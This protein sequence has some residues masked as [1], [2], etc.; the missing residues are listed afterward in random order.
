[1][2]RVLIS[3]LCA[4]ILF[5]FVSSVSAQNMAGQNKPY[6]NLAYWYGTQSAPTSLEKAKWALDDIN[7][8]RAGKGLSALPETILDTK[9]TSIKDTRFRILRKSR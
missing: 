9:S 7:S 4:A 1:M 8:Y 6:Q 3:L 5:V 2:R